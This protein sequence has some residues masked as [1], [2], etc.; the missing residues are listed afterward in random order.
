M[1]RKTIPPGLEE[2]TADECAETLTVSK[3]LYAKLWA[4]SND[5]LTR[6][7][8]TPC[9][10]DGTDGTVEAPD[11]RLGT[12]WADKVGSFWAS[13]TED[14]RGKLADAYE[15]EN[16]GWDLTIPGM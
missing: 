2:M 15:E 6:G 4:I 10:G 11:D 1:T 9:G 14:E 13:L 8:N 12:H 5:A 7:S 3:E 16:Q